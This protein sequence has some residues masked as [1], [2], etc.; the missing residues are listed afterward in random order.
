MP[1]STPIPIPFISCSSWAQVCAGLLPMLRTAA[2]QNL[3]NA[4]WALAKLGYA[5]SSRSSKGTGSSSLSYPCPCGDFLRAVVAHAAQAV[6]H[7]PVKAAV[8]PRLRHHRVQ[9]VALDTSCQPWQRGA[10]SL[11]A[12]PG[13]Q[14]TSK[15]ASPWPPPYHVYQRSTQV[16]G[17]QSQS[18]ANLVWALASTGWLAQ[19]GGEPLL[20]ALLYCPYLYCL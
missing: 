2:A 11:H 1:L 19:E 14:L 3:T 17:W 18:V 5:H 4:A 7:M 9:A 10:A 13:L 8:R 6:G 15:S 12:S 16:H 20:L